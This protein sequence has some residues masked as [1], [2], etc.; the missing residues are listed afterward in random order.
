MAWNN[1][2]KVV[3]IVEV[4]M[5]WQGITKG[6]HKREGLAA[7]IRN[8]TKQETIRASNNKEFESKKKNI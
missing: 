1:D 5:E 3:K 4:E 7:K 8:I 6:M 2:T